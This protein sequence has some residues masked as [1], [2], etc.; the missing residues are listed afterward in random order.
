MSAWILLLTACLSNE[1]LVFL[2][3]AEISGPVVRLSDVV[4]LNRLPP[5]VLNRAKLVEVHRV[6]EGRTSLSSRR[7]A[8]RARAALPA[9]AEWLP[10]GLDRIILIESHST[11]V[12][13]SGGVI[14]VAPAPQI[15]VGAA[16]TVAVRI[17]PVTIQ[18]E[19]RAMQAGWPGHTLFVRTEDGQVLTGR[20]GGAR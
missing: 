17:G 10:D 8:A 6:A 7:V 1:P 12:G 14:Q 11:P 13:S 15:A 16:V 9:L 18:R 20:V 2:D 4:V 3:R 19:A 5:A